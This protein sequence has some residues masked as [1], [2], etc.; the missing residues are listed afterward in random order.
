MN[1]PIIQL[2]VLAGIA[3]FLILRLKNVLGTRDGFEPTERPQSL[4]GDASRRRGF[5]VIDGGPDHDIIDHVPEDSEAA[6]ALAEM[7]RAEPSFEVGPFLQ[8]ARGAYE[9]ILMG[10][11]RGQLDDLVPFLDEDVYNTFSEV[12]D[13]RQEK[14]LTIEAEFVGV[15]EIELVD[16]SYDATTKK[17]DVTV[18]FVGELISVVRGKDG[19]IV[20]GEVGKAKRQKDVWTFERTMG[21]DDPNW[22]LV[23]TGE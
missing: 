22:R 5:E 12:V 14:G 17:G 2:L 4:P 6:A 9:M 20:E 15:R 8:G 16:A 21:A 7:K 3:V 19:E 23:A 11:E 1:S 10:F 13:M 18:R